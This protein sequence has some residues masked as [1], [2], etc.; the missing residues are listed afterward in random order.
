MPV[1]LITLAQRESYGR[2]VKP[3]TPDELSRCFHIHDGDRALITLKRGNHNRLGFALQLVT[4]RFIGIFLEDPLEVPPA[5]AQMVSKQLEI[6]DFDSL[7]EYR[8]GKQRW[9][10]KAEICMSYGYREITDPKM[11]FRFCRWL[12]AL[13]WTGTNRPSVLFDR[14]KIW[15]LTN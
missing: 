7:H 8:T 11:G 10:H 12:Y 2:Y 14:A 6:T 13:C 15:L 9:E 5:I 1:N 4:V 3:P